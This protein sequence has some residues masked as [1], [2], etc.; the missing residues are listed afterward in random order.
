MAAGEL[1]VVVQTCRANTWET[2][3]AQVKV[4]PDYTEFQAC[5]G[6]V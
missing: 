2:G 6:C 3:T 4:I 1:G 5:P